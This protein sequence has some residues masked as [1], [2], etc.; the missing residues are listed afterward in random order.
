MPSRSARTQ[1]NRD[2]K[3]WHMATTTL[4]S[5]GHEKTKET[6][7]YKKLLISK[8][9]IGILYLNKVK[10][11]RVCNFIIFEIPILTV[12]IIYVVD[13]IT[14]KIG[15]SNIIKLQTLTIFALF[16]WFFQDPYSPF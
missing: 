5:N 6:S 14:V 3:R 15:I 9:K 12:E 16:R 10:T 4:S 7:K 2:Q 13:H 8:R 1:R 11:V